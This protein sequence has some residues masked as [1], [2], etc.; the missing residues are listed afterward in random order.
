MTKS[1]KAT[2]IESALCKSWKGWD[3][4]VEDLYF[5]DVELQPEI[6]AKCVEG[7][8]HP[9]SEVAVDINM[10]ELSGKVISFDE[11]GDEVFSLPFTLNVSPVFE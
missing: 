11:A 1:Y 7:G 6:L 3:G 10:L 5:Y 8:M 9:D 2:G 4:G